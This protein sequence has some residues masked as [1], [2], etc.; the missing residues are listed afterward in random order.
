MKFS[1]SVAWILI[2]FFSRMPVVAADYLI[3]PTSKHKR[4]SWAMLHMSMNVEL[5][6]GLI[7]FT[8]PK[9]ATEI[10]DSATAKN[11]KKMIWESCIGV[12]VTRNETEEN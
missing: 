2:E 3:G 8:S 10:D 12:P 5:N 4:Q 6:L 1:L 11:N 9:T 7:Q